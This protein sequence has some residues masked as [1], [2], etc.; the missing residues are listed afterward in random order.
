MKV[1]IFDTETTGLPKCR[2]SYF[3]QTELWPHIIQL[4][5][6]LYETD[7]NIIIHSQDNII[8]IDDKVELT[9]DSVNMHKIT[10]EISKSKGIEIRSAIK[11]FNKILNQADIIVSHNV[12]FDKNMILV[13]CIRLNEKHYFTIDNK[14]KPEFCT[15]KGTREFCNITKID[16]NTGKEYYKYPKLSELY[17]LLFNQLPKN[18]HNSMVDVLICLRC[19][20]KYKFGKDLLLDNENNDYKELFNTYC[21]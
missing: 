11:K 2:N 5:Y 3:T 18:C 4:S 21:V 7:T 10:R 12:E 8:K 16:N 9:E 17:K 14:R 19:Y 15:M 6:I 1:L 13:E 20:I